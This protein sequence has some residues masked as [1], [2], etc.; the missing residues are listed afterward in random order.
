L[1]AHGV[2]FNLLQKLEQ[3]ARTNPRL[4]IDP[5]GFHKALAEKRES[6]EREVNKEKAETKLKPEVHESSTNTKR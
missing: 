2:Y 4:W 6:F 5:A 1:G 3:G